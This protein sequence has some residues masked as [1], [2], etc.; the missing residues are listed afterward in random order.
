ML[1]LCCDGGTLQ[2]SQACSIFLDNLGGRESSDAVP[3]RS[4]RGTYPINQ[5][6]TSPALGRFADSLRGPLVVIALPCGFR[7]RVV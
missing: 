4:E 5:D 7:G 3:L 1:R 2:R 6:R